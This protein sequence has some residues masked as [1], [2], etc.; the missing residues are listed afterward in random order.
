MKVDLEYEKQDGTGG[1]PTSAE[2]R[3]FD[4]LKRRGPLCASQLSNELFLPLK[5]VIQALA[6]LKSRNV[7]EQRRSR[8]LVPPDEATA[9][10]G[11]STRIFR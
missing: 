8:G 7:V 6:A 5:E 2:E 11:L 10:W 1:R 9:P 3:V 4:L